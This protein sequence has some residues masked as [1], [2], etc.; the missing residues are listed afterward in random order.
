MTAREYRQQAETLK[1]E[2]DL[3]RGQLRDIR[4]QRDC[5]TEAVKKMAGVK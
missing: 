5:L 2:N 4:E 3:L 1:R